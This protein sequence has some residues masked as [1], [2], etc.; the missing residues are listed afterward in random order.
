MTAPIVFGLFTRFAAQPAARGAQP[1]LR[2]VTDPQAQDG[3]YYGPG[4]L[5]EGRGSARKVH[6]TKTAHD[7]QLAGRLWQA[8]ETLTGVTFPGLPGPAKPPGARRAGVS[9]PGRAVLAPSCRA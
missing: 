8:F 2:A 1:V 4:G 7:E 3:G 5:G 6:C 9:C